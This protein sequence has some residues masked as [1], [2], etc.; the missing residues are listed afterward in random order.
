[1]DGNDNPADLLTKNVDQQKKNK[2][3][4]MSGQVYREGKADKSLELASIKEEPN[5]EAMERKRKWM[6]KKSADA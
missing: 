2:F 6:A 3:M 5:S 1:M 4:E